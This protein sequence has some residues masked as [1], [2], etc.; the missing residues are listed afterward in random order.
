MTAES[1]AKEYILKRASAEQSFQNN[2]ESLYDD[3]AARLVDLAYAVNIHPNDFS[4]S[5]N[6]ALKKKVDAL[7]ANLLYDITDYVETLSVAD[8]TAHKQDILLH[9]NR[10]IGISD[11][12]SRSENHVQSFKSEIEG[13]LAAALLVGVSKTNIKQS[14]RTYRRIPFQ[15]PAFQQAIKL[16]KG[17]AQVLVNKGQHLGMGI[18]NASYVAINTLGRF[19]IADAW[20]YDDYLGM[21]AQGAIGYIGHRG[22]SFPCSLCDEAVNIFHAISEGMIYP[23]H[24]RCV[25]YVTPVFK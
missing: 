3:Y 2:L 6:P 5:A 16:N 19:T 14:I 21:D 4:F 25:C 12:S 9:I 8:H 22:S 20:M 24:P 7:M 11:F 10:K 23:L 1:T 18:S 15:N 13:I 17:V